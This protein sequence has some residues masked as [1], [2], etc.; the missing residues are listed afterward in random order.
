MVA[1]AFLMG[2][3]YFY[4]GLIYFGVVILVVLGINFYLSKR[5]KNDE[6]IIKISV[7]EDM[8]FEKCFLM[9]S[10]KNMLK[11]YKL[12]KVKSADMGTTFVLS[13][14][15]IPKDNSLKSLLDEIRIRN[16]NMNLLLTKK[17]DTQMD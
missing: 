3:G 1:Y 2:L 11:S 17:L 8:N 15:F 9:M 12:F 10:L 14:S 7:P 5:K 4:L 6:Y 16:G 13:Y